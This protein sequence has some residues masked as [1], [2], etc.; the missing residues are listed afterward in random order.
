MP[1]ELSEGYVEAA[2]AAGDE[3]TLLALPGTG[4]FEVIDPLCARVAGDS[5]G[6]QRAGREVTLA[7]VW[8]RGV[9]IDSWRVKS[10]LRE[11]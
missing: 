10:R 3:A 5:G 6:D 7:S 1:F 8:T 2:R 9:G 4:H 11:T